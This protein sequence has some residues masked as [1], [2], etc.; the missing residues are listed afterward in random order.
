MAY[1]T[2]NSTNAIWQ[3]LYGTGLQEV[4]EEKLLGLGLFSDKESMFPHGDNLNLSQ[5]GSAVLRDYVENSP[6]DF[7]AID[8][9][10]VN[11]SVTEYKQDGF[12]I[13]DKNKQD[14]PDGGASLFAGRVKASMNA[15]AEGIETDVLA[16]ANAFQTPGGQNI[17]NFQPHRAALP[18][19][20]T[21][22]DIVDAIADIKLSFDKARVPEIGRVLIVDSTLENVLNKAQF[23]TTDNRHFEGLV[24]TGFAQQHRFFRNLHGFD[25][26]ISNLLPTISSE[27]VNSV[28]V[29]DGVANIAMCLAD[30]DAMPMMGVIRQPPSPEFARDTDNKV[31]KWS[32]TA[33]WGFA[34]QRPESL[35]C[36]LSQF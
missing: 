34:V 29:T 15:F 8:L 31:D 19:T 1:T 12:Y 5:I 25:L 35:Y 2:S 20:A 23:L 27:T 32:A 22:Q 9:G 11:L 4:F 18:A 10:R 17:I 28:A 21:A 33:R 13:T 36:L 16:K 3:E 30:D 14:L 24:N 6:I 7:S 26:W